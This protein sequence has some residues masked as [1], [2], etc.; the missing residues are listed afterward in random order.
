MKNSNCNEK[1][2]IWTS[3]V[4]DQMAEH[5]KKMK[6]SI[7]LFLYLLIHADKA[8][9]IVLKKIDAICLDTG[10][11]RHTITRWLNT[12]KKQGYVTTRNT[13]RY[14]Y[15]QI[16]L[17]KNPISDIIKNKSQKRD[18]FNSCSMNN[19]TTDMSFKKQ[20]D[21]KFQK[22]PKEPIDI[23]INNNILK[24]DI[25]NKRPRNKEELLAYDMAQQLNDYKGLAFYL[26]CSKKYSE[27]FLRE[28]LSQVRQIPS[29][30]IKK[31]RAALFNHLIQKYARQNSQNPGN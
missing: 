7:W 13:G 27:P 15:I 20:N 24:I 9:G 12:L 4:Y 5:Y 25:D 30:K 23:S 2:P 11:K 10:I 22:K 29:G 31:S 6:N 26:S 8:K 28:L 1:S 18:I 3:L 16:K 14:L 19:P 21:F 17:W